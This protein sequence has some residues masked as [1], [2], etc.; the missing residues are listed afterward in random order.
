MSFKRIKPQDIEGNPFSMI[1]EEW[2]LITGGNA[3]GF[4]SMTASWGALGVQWEKPV[5]HCLVRPTRHTYKFIDQCDYYT[6]S[7]YDSKYADKLSYFGTVSGRDEDK[8]K[9]SGFTPKIL[10]C[11]AAC[12]EEANLILVCKKLYYHDINPAAFKV[13]EIEDNYPKKDYHR[14]YVGEIVE[15]LSSH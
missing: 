7:F 15:V 8:V 6:L 12:Y 5:A 9:G 10:D 14:V 11:G 1:G 13:P 2:M 4:N 3:D